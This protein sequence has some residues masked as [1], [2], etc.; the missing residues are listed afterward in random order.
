MTAHQKVIDHL[1]MATVRERIASDSLRDAQ[2]EMQNASQGLR[3]AQQA[4]ADEQDRMLIAAL[5][6][7]SA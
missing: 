6:A 7:I 1:A 4:V 3:S 5:E 2:V